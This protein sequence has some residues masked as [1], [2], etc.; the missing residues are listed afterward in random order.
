MTRD[1]LDQI[2]QAE[3][4]EQARVAHHLKVC[5]A[6]SC[7]SSRSDQVKAALEKE[8]EA[9]DVGHKCKVSG[10]GCLGLCK[11]GPLV[12]VESQGRIYQNVTP[13]DA[14]RVVASIEGDAAVEL[15]GDLTHP[16]FTAQ[17]KIA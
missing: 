12:S 15:L 5:V 10:V 4:E 16:F 13:E 17:K 2:A 1:D 14:P 8:I 11:A 3:Q 7:L 6:A 9:Q